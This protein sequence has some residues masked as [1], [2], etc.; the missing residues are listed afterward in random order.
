MNY[1]TNLNS[2]SF[3]EKILN[4]DYSGKGHAWNSYLRS[5]KK[6]IHLVDSILATGGSG[7][8]ETI[9]IPKEA[10]SKY[11]TKI[12]KNLT[13][14]EQKTILLDLDETLVHSEPY[15]SSKTYDVVINMAENGSPEEVSIP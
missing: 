9:V 13:F 12:P 3:L 10:G 15:Q 7:Q 11:F 2:R 6:E 5:L 14:L 1:D 4:Q 8:G